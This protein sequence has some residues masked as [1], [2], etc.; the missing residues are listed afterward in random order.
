MRSDWFSVAAVLRLL[1]AHGNANDL[2]ERRRGMT[3]IRADHPGT[4]LA[5]PIEDLDLLR[6]TWSTGLDP[7]Q[8]PPE[9]R[10]YGS[11]AL[12]NVCK[13]HRSIAS[14]PA[15]TALRKSTYQRV[16]DRWSELGFVEPPPTLNVFHQE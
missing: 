9:L 12:I 13:P 10:P 4:R 16:V 15:A 7:S 6:N 14:F 2:H 11:K 5:N 3:G 8:Y 1:S